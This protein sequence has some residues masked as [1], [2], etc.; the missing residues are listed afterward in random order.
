MYAGCSS[1]TESDRRRF[2]RQLPI[3]SSR[4]RTPQRRVGRS[5]GHSGNVVDRLPAGGSAASSRAFY[6]KCRCGARRCPYAHRGARSAS[7]GRPAA[8]P[9]GKRYNAAPSCFA[10][11]SSAS[12]ASTRSPTTTCSTSVATST[13]SI[14]R[15]C[16]EVGGIRFGILICEDYWYPHVPAAARDAGAQA[17]LAL[18]ASPFH[19]D[20][21]HLRIDMPDATSRRWGCPSCRPIS[22][23]GRTNWYSTACPSRSTVAAN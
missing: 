23:A 19:L 18:N 4:L 12:I 20:K 7:A 5:P 8:R 17:L 9:E 3:A 22:S 10:A 6:A 16:F 21:Q 13:R 2:L 15:C 14:S 11:L 1:S